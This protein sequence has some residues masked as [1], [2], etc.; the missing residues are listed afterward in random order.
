MQERSLLYRLWWLFKTN[1]LISCLAIGGGYMIIPLIKKQFVDNARA[2][3]FDELL[4]MAAIAQSA[5]GAIAI[6]LSAITGYKVAGFL[7]A[8]IAT[9]SCVISGF[10]I[11]LVGYN[12]FC[13]H[14]N[15]DVIMAV[16]QGLKAVATGLIG[17]AGAGILLL[18]LTGHNQLSL[19]VQNF[20]VPALIIALASFVLLRKFRLNPV[21]VLALSAGAGIV[22]Y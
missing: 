5:P 16:L 3:N 4:E 11:S 10:A 12:F 19:N 8:V 2:F 6:N 21:T 13:S 15:S 14:R 17:S 20:D 18:A 7:G 9:V 1:V 22:F